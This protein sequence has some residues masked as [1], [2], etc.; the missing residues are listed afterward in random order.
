MGWVLS[1]SVVNSFALASLWLFSCP[2]LSAQQW[3]I[4]VEAFFSDTSTDIS[5]YETMTTINSI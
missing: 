1:R 2:Q 4:E 5:V 3:E